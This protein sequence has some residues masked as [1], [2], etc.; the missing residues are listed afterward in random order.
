MGRLDG[1][2]VLVTAA[3]Q[4]I[5]RACALACAR[6]GAGVTA[7]DVRGDEL[8][9]LNAM[10]IETAVLDGADAGAVTAFLKQMEPVQS[11]IHCIGRVHQGSVLDCP[12]EEWRRSFD[13]NVDTFY[14]L[15]RAILP[16]MVA[17]GGGS[18]V[19]ISSVVSSLKGFQ[20][21]A[22]YGATKAALIGLMKSVAADYVT[23]GVRCN[24]V[25][26]G[27]IL[28]PSFQDRVEELGRQVGGADKA[29]QMFVARQPMGRLGTPEEVADL[30]VYLSG[31][32]SRFVTGQ[33]FAIDGGIT[34]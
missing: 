9:S 8:K 28:S 16:S 30:C 4:G 6:E 20:N 26:P 19:C 2:R 14:H 13:L 24:A 15:L 32:E 5:G 22:A 29:M 12:P 31:D 34:I 25:C 27:T 33:A 1:R 3:G 23:A 21:R 7:T 18:I 17:Q 10:G 11:A